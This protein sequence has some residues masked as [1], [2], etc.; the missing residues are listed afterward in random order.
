MNQTIAV[1]QLRQSKQIT[2]DDTIEKAIVCFNKEAPWCRHFIHKKINHVSIAIETKEGEFCHMTWTGR[3]IALQAGAV[4]RTEY[5]RGL[6]GNDVLAVEYPLRE[7]WTPCIGP[8][9]C[10][11]MVKRVLGL[12]PL[13]MH[14]LTPYQ[15]YGYLRRS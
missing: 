14:V 9:T 2:E 7:D 4:D 3:R 11:S 5:I 12:G 15:L 1:G 6:W 8:F 10:V 13:S